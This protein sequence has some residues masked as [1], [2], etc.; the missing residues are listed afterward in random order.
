[1]SSVAFPMALIP[2]TIPSIASPAGPNRRSPPSVIARSLTRINPPVAFSNASLIPFQ[3]NS[4][5]GKTDDTRFTIGFVKSPIISIIPAIPCWNSL[6][7]VTVSRSP[8][9]KSAIP[10]TVAAIAAMH[11]ARLAPPAPIIAAPSPFL[12]TPEVRSLANFS[13]GA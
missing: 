3:P 4:K 10:E 11:D 9:P 12:K 2:R 6:L 1:M 13:I 8:A 7:F 5:S